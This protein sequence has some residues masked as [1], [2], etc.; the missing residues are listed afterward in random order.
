MSATV[1]TQQ[2]LVLEAAQRKHKRVRALDLV[3]LLATVV[4]LLGAVLWAFPLYW[5]VV[6]SLKQDA[7]VVKAGVK[8][9]PEP[10][11]LDAYVHALFG[12]IMGLW[13]VNSIVTAVATTVIVLIM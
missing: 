3:G 4:T 13:Y 5:A 7:D 9:W 10:I 1:S 12:T 2:D 11:T 8:L 6:T